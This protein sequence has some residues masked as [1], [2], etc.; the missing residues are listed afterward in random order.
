MA[1]RPDCLGNHD[2]E[3]HLGALSISR[4]FVFVL[5]HFPPMMVEFVEREPCA[6]TPMAVSLRDMTSSQVTVT[7]GAFRGQSGWASAGQVRGWK[8]QQ[9]RKSWKDVRGWHRTAIQ[10]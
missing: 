5:K 4:G 3:K 8:L 9:P 10:G 7:R 6:R 1:V 2:K